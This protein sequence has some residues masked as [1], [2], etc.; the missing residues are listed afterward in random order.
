MLALELQESA[1]SGH[2]WKFKYSDVYNIN[3]DEAAEFDKNFAMK[4]KGYQPSQ[5]IFS[6]AFRSFLK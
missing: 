1:F 2:D 6:I 3:E 4:Q 5:D